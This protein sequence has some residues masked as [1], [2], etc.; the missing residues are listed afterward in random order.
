M[1]DGKFYII[2]DLGIINEEGS[3]TLTE[4]KEELKEIRDRINNGVPKGHNVAIVK[5][6]GNYNNFLF[7]NERYE[8]KNGMPIKD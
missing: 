7:G 5:V 8:L 4:A 1:K 2:D 6:E 3:R